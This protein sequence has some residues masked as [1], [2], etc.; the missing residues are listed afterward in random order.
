MA[1]SIVLGMQII[2]TLKRKIKYNKAN[3]SLGAPLEIR[4]AAEAAF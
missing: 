3:N 4:N 2:F 1:S